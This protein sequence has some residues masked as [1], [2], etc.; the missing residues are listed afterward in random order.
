MSTF[1]D[2]LAG[3]HEVPDDVTIPDD[4]EF[5][6]V[7]DE[8][9]V[10]YFPADYPAMWR[11]ADCSA[12]R[13]LTPEPL[14]ALPTEEGIYLDGDGRVWRRRQDR[15]VPLAE[16]GTVPESEVPWM[17][18]RLLPGDV[19]DESD[20]RP[21]VDRDGDRWGWNGET[22]RW[23]AL[24]W[25]RLYYATKTEIEASYGPLDYADEEA[26]NE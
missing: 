16:G 2:L 1:N 10:G 6:A 25:P 21:V 7:Y 4:W 23:V 11:D 13:R 5:I 19:L 20:K 3:W 18:S 22:E 24:S 8:G 12:V 9:V 14:Y 26:S 17:L 15:W